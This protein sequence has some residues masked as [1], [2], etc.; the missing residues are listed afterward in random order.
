MHLALAL[1]T[2]PYVDAVRTWTYRMATC[3]AVHPRASIY[4]AVKPVHTAYSDAFCTHACGSTATTVIYC[5]SNLL[6]HAAQIELVMWHVR[7]STYDDASCV[8]AAIEIMLDYNVAVHQ[9]Q[10]LTC[11]RLETGL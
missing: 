9:A 11:L 2:A 7:L 10:G 4:G 1:H 3:V 5:D 8:N 6:L